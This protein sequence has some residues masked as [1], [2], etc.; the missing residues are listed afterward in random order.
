[1]KLDI[2]DPKHARLIARQMQ[3]KPPPSS[4][5]AQPHLTWEQW[6]ALAAERAAVLNAVTT[7]YEQQVKR[8]E[9]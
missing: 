8:G 3:A 9:P 6:S 7:N 2:R 1:M 4:W 5:W